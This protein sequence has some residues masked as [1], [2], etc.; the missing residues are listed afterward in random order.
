MMLNLH[1][2]ANVF[3]FCTTAEN[4]FKKGAKKSAGT[5]MQKSLVGGNLSELFEENYPLIFIH[6][7]AGENL[8]RK[9]FI[10]ISYGL[11]FYQ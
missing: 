9:L 2:I 6:I 8:K 10:M 1:L 5:K 4:L 7:N 11:W 3:L